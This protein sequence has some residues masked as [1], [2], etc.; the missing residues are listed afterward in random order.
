MED[1]SS[2]AILRQASPVFEL[3]PS[4][5][6]IAKA[7]NTHFIGILHRSGRSFGAGVG[8]R[9][10]DDRIKS[11]RATRAATELLERRLTLL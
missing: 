5:R 4:T 3:Q 8:S 11:I 2:T 9:H 1:R 6:W 7:K 10:I